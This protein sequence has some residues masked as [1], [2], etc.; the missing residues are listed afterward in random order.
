MGPKSG[1]C[2][3][4]VSIEPIV[5]A[6]DVLW[7][8]KVNDSTVLFSSN[9][10]QRELNATAVLTCLA[11]RV[12]CKPACNL[13]LKVGRQ[14]GPCGLART[15]VPCQLTAPPGLPLWSYIG[16]DRGGALGACVT[17]V[18]I[19]PDS[20][21]LLKMC[22]GHSSSMIQQYCLFKSVAKRVSEEVWQIWRSSEHWGR[23]VV[24]YPLSKSQDG[25]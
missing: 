8:L 6:Q 22:C 5:S 13:H 24:C 21:Q 15:S 18:S 7:S 11:G 20:A 12:Q 23:W 4:F 10:L 2:M 9:P 19:E 17:L 3:T 25:L 16:N 1:A 14:L